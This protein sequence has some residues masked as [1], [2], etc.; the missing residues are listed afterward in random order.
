M[1]YYDSTDRNSTDYTLFGLGF[2]AV[3]IG[4]TGIVINSPA[5]ATLGLLLLLAV[6][7]GVAIRN[8]PSGW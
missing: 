6:I 7:A 1:N 5:L 2:I 8:D 3:L 4:A